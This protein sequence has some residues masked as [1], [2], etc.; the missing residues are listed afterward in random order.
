MTDAHPRLY[1]V[2]AVVHALGIFDDI[3][4]EYVIA[5]D[6]IR[7]TCASCPGSGASVVFEVP[8]ENIVAA[9]RDDR[10]ELEV[11]SRLVHTLLLR[12]P[13]LVLMRLAARAARQREH[14]AA[15]V[16]VIE[17]AGGYMRAEDQ[18]AYRAARE[19]LAT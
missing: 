12:D 3:D 7:V 8:N 18:A 1:S 15:M 10:L 4:S 6:T 2:R 5:T 14:L 16:A 13:D 19:E 9:I 17:R 11:M